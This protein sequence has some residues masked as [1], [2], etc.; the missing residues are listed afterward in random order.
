MADPNSEHDAPTD[1]E[2]DLSRSDFS[3]RRRKMTTR[4]SVLF[5]DRA[6]SSIITV[7]GIGT[8]LSV[9]GVAV[10][11]AYVVMPL[12]LPSQ[13]DEFSKL[14][15]LERE[16][17]RGVGLDEYR[18]LGWELGAEGD[19][20]IFRLDNGEVLERNQ[21]FEGAELTA[22]SFQIRGDQAAFGFADG[23]VRLA[24]VSFVTEILDAEDLPAET[25]AAFEDEDAVVNYRE[26]VLEKTPSAQYRLQ[27]LQI[28][29]GAAVRLAEGQIRDLSHT[30][31]PGGPVIAAIVQGRR[32][33]EV[34]LIEADAAEGADE[35]AEAA[36]ATA[37]DGEVEG[38]P[39][40][41]EKAPEP[42][43]AV[44]TAGEQAA[45]DAQVG[46][47]VLSIAEDQNFLTGETVVEV[48]GPIELELPSGARDVPQTLAISG[49]GVELYTV[50]RDGFVTRYDIRNLSSASTVETGFL[51]DPE[52]SAEINFFEPIIGATSFIWGDTEGRIAGGFPVRLADS[53]EPLPELIQ[54]ERREGVLDAFVR[55]KILADA[56]SPATSLAASERTRLAAAG[57]E[58]GSVRFFNVTNSTQIG[59]GQVPGGAPIR[60]LRIA[61]KEDGVL[62][63][64]PDGPYVADF[65]P[66]YPE[67]GFAAFF[68]PVWYEG[69]AE[70][71]HIWQSSSASDDFEMKLGLMPLIFGTLKATFYSMLFGAPLALLAALFTSEYLSGR[72]KAIIKPSI[73]LMASLPSVVLGFLAALVIA[74]YIEDVVPAT[75]TAF[76]TVPACFLLGAYLWQLLPAKT[77][78]LYKEWRIALIGLLVPIGVVIAALLGPLVERLLFLGDIKAWLAWGP[79]SGLDERFADPT[80][81]W[82]LLMIPVSA[83]L[84]ALAV[85]RFVNPRMRDR[86]T[87]WDRRQYATA[88]L[89][90]FLSCL[91]VMVIVAYAL[92]ALLAA[93]GLDP[94]GG[95]V[96]TYVQRNALIVGFAMGFAI[97]PI[98]YTISEDAL[99]TVPSHLRSASLG[100]GAT[101]WQTATRIII[102][103][104]MSGLFSALM[105]GLGRAVGETMIVLMA[106]GNT[107][108][109]EMNIFEGFRTLS[110]NIAVELP[111]AVKGSTHYRTLFLAAL[112][113]FILT[114]VVNTV[115]EVIRQRF[116]KR[117]YQL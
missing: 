53:E 18:V 81:G 78:I 85:G 87:E 92:S 59:V 57:F 111:E 37:D 95:Y 101:R 106:A 107:P 66:R 19:L 82:M 46:L 1:G 117:A 32:F 105:I 76:V 79:D 77:T 74:P 110:A 21:L 23:S 4:K 5:A 40:A 10:F 54:A 24:N 62:A 83:L 47:V 115:A 55:T 17:L 15:A 93:L 28:E 22:S 44:L 75:L 49:A 48:E 6:A 12:F 20:T 102:P 41:V 86:G 36:A 39:A 84:V 26:G 2:E 52:G 58:D 73:E 109:M 64:T 7:G 71:R 116:R 88:D 90:K 29:L 67:A 30:M 56:D 80:G 96:D 103:T 8:I 108:V 45:L 99:S 98:I 70:E 113:L 51:I 33:S 104:A 43:P 11:L 13:V 91:V 42:E 114:F 69:Y 112:V 72:P 14:P 9:L 3:V 34:Q 25:L 60:Q 68:A 35:A 97:I 89:I 63:V 31:T 100:A 65:D 38:E 61:P 50:W 94:R 27:E 16:K